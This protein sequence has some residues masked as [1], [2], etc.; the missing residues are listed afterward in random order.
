MTI[1]DMSILTFLSDRQ[2]GLLKSITRMFPESAHGLCVNHLKENLKLVDNRLPL[3]RLVFK[4]TKAKSKNQYENILQEIKE[5][6]VKAEEYLRGID[7]TEYVDCFFAGKR[8]GHYTSN[9]SE[10]LNSKILP[11]REELPIQCF[12]EF[13]RKYAEIF[14]ERRTTSSK[15]ESKLPPQVNRRLTESMSRARQSYKVNR[16]GAMQFDVRGL[17]KNYVVDLV[18][19]TCTCCQ[20]LPGQSVSM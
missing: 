7:P 6:S 1:P 5:I 2:K 9:I 3:N 10:S 14:V 15:I 11:V 16:T 13:I 20:S 4:L 19:R 18:E 17:E 8:F 12:Q